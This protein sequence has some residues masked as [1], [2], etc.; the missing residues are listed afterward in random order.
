MWSGSDY[1]EQ[2]GVD[3]SVGKDLE[4]VFLDEHKVLKVEHPALSHDDG[5]DV[6]HMFSLEG[7]V[8]N[9]AEHGELVALDAEGV[10]DVGDVEG[11]GRA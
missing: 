3:L 6:E 1:A 4:A 9:R 11:Q 2:T 10:T 7:E 5:L 8:L